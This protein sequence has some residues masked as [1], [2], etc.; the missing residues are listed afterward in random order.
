VELGGPCSGTAETTRSRG[1]A[2]VPPR[3]IQWVF[4]TDSRFDG[5]ADLIP[6]R[7]RTRSAEELTGLG[8]EQRSG[9]QTPAGIVVSIEQ[10]RRQM[11][12][13]L[14]DLDGLERAVVSAGA[15]ALAEGRSDAFTLVTDLADR[16]RHDDA[17][18]ERLA[19]KLDEHVPHLLQDHRRQE[20]SDAH[21]L[22]PLP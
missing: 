11:A 14:E 18:L 4:G 2:D 1:P 7:P 9:R 8:P 13:L 12:Q 15:L 17:R 19:E 10:H 16:L 3:D 5:P 20:K 22:R 21:A 6:L